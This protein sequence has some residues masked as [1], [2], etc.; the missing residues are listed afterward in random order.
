MKN[1]KIF[2]IALSVSLLTSSLSGVY[3]SYA[4]SEVIKNDPSNYEVSESMNEFEVLAPTPSITQLE[5]ELYNMEDLSKAKLPADNKETSEVI[6]KGRKIIDPVLR[7]DVYNIS[8]NDIEELIKQGFTIEDIFKADEL[9]NNIYEDPKSLLKMKAETGKSLEE[10]KDD[11]IK[12]RKAK[13]VNSI[14]DKHEKEYNKLQKEGFTDDEIISFISYLDM[15]QLQLTDSLIGEYKISDEKIF[16]EKNNKLSAEF[17]KKYKISDK[18]AVGLT[19]DLVKAMEKLS[20][21]TGK[22][23]RELLESIDK[24]NN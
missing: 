17:K 24:R 1:K 16:K 19:D 4:K 23:V 10:V 6:Y 18:E 13:A 3:I 5:P 11:M 8:G 9:A 20:K 22:P 15:N 21:K 12:E 7:K 2:A 14:K